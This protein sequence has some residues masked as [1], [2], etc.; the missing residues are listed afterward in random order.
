MVINVPTRHFYSP[1]ETK[2][3][4]L[5]LSPTSSKVRSRMQSTVSMV[6]DQP[7]VEVM[8]C[9]F[10]TILKICNHHT[11]NS[12][13]L[14][15]FLLVLSMAVKKQRTF[16]LVSTNSKRQKLKSSIENCLCLL[17]SI[18]KNILSQVGILKIKIRH[19]SSSSTGVKSLEKNVS[20]LKL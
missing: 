12:D 2:T 6:M 3:T 19:L 11:A 8:I 17:P 20:S 16:L 1:C 15:N 14:I 5:H 4:L 18:N 13:I 10:V 7:L 9:T